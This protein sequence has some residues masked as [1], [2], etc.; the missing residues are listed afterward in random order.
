MTSQQTQLTPAADLAAQNT[1]RHPN[2]SDEYRRARQQLLAEEIELR[3][4]Q[5]RVASLRRDL[6]PGGEVPREYHCVATVR[7]V[8]SVHGESRA[9][10]L[11]RVEI[12]R[13]APGIDG[14]RRDWAGDEVT[15][16]HVTT[17]VRQRSHDTF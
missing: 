3:R 9:D 10:V 12:A 4:T 16:G 6:P 13:R 5:E 1:I 14:G 8:G 15:L 11:R 2:E 7:P 17:D